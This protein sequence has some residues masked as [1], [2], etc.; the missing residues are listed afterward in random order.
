MKLATIRTDGATRA[1]RVDT[2]SCVPVGNFADVGALLREQNWQELAR[3]ADGPSRPLSGTDFAPPVTRPGKVLCV[4]ANYREHIA[5]MGAEVPEHPTLFAKFAEALI[6]A[7]DEIDL[8]DEDESVDWEA[9][10]AIIIGTP[11]RRVPEA[12]AADHIAGYAVLNDVSMRSYQFRT[13]QWLQG[14][15]WESST[16]FGPYLVSPDEFSPSEAAVTTVLDG[17]TV[18]DG[19]TR[20]L[21]FTP[22]AVVS[23]ISTIITLQPG[24]VI[25]TGTPSGVGAA[26]TPPRWMSDGSV[27]ETS[28][29]GLG[30][31]RNRVGRNGAV[32]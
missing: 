18:Q 29:A 13:N 24:D 32:R 26:R 19:S 30:S 1:V 9:E 7:H 6:G 31:Q 14:K 4:G 11:A 12:D 5:E 17:D 20:D 10:L 15:T 16:P 28:I 3:Q 27:L 2:D 25:A 23:Y 22:A 8:P 21:V